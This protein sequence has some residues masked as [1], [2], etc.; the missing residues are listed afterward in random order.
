MRGRARNLFYQH[1][2]DNWSFWAPTESN[3]LTKLQKTLSFSA[4]QSLHNE[5]L[6]SV[7]ECLNI[8][9]ADSLVS[10][11]S[12]VYLITILERT[13]LYFDIFKK[14]LQADKDLKVATIAQEAILP[15]LKEMKAK[16][17]KMADLDYQIA[18]L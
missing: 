10:N 14:G 13:Q 6:V 17:E 8:L 16:K 11:E 5:D 2:R 7:R 3:A 15:K 1:I 18:K 12:V 4:L 9:A